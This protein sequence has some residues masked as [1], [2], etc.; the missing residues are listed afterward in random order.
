MDDVPNEETKREGSKVRK[1]SSTGSAGLQ[2]LQE[3][4]N[5]DLLGGTNDSEE[6]LLLMGTDGGQRRQQ[7]TKVG[8]GGG[9]SAV[10]FPG[11]PNESKRSLKARLREALKK[12]EELRQLIGRLA[13]ER[14]QYF[15]RSRIAED[16]LETVKAELETHRH[17]V[18]MFREKRKEYFL[19][20]RGVA[21]ALDS[22]RTRVQ[23]AIDA[24]SNSDDNEKPPEESV[25]AALKI[26]NQ[27]MQTVKNID[28]S[29][30]QFDPTSPVE[31]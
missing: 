5:E 17:H 15:D 9:N 13:T 4:S 29:C 8:G 24:L 22:V 2:K 30:L 10:A 6:D 20:K 19:F 21:V 31:A 14:D 12:R 11:E 26:L 27:L 18:G 28:D 23:D 16:E 7:E 1:R 25:S 3:D